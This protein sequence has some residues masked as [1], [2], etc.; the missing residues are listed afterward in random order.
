MVASRSS[1]NDLSSVGEV[2]SGASK[3][4]HGDSAAVNSALS[5]IGSV[6]VVELLSVVL[7]LILVVSVTELVVVLVQSRFRAVL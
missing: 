2:V 6:V 7:E 1:G 4:G 5:S 3:L